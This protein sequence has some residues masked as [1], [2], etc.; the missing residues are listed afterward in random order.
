V[1]A[2]PAPGLPASNFSSDEKCEMQVDD[3]RGTHLICGTAGETLLFALH[4]NGI[5]I[6]A[7]CGGNMICGTCHVWLSPQAGLDHP[8][9]QE[10]IEL[11]ELSN[12]YRPNRSRLACQVQIPRGMCGLS[13]EVAPDE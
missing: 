3:E 11:L 4:S 7:V 1:F 9:A 2:H 13:L 6:G 5:A 12:F 10:E 8:P